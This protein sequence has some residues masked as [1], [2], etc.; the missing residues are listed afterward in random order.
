MALQT[1][2]NG[3]KEVTG[4]EGI[5]NPGENIKV[6]VKGPFFGADDWRKQSHE[7]ED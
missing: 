2:R 5:F 4:R 6:T 3:A 1:S 7:I